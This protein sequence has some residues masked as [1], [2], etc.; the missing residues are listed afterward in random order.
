MSEFVRTREMNG[1]PVNLYAAP[2]SATFWFEGGSSLAILV[3]QLR[4]VWRYKYDTDYTLTCAEGGGCGLLSLHP[5]ETHPEVTLEF[6][7]EAVERTIKKHH[8]NLVLQ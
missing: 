1:R 3:D 6:I 7:R 8:L 2:Y 4:Q 5:P